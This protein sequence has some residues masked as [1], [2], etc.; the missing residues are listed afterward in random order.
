MIKNFK[1]KKRNNGTRT[2]LSIQ[3]L[4]GLRGITGFLFDPVFQG[5][6]LRDI[7]TLR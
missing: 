6:F 2:E 1:I 5:S 4:T 7:L 3:R